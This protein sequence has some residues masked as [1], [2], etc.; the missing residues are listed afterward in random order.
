MNNYYKTFRTKGTDRDELNKQTLY[1]LYKR[2]KKESTQP[3]YDTHIAEDNT[4]QADLLYMPVD[5][6]YRYALVIVDIGTGRVEAE[7]L[8]SRTADVVRDAFKTIYTDKKR[9][10]RFPKLLQVDD[11]GEFKG[12]CEA[13]LESKGVLLR[14]GKAG[15]SRQ[16]A[17]VEKLNGDIA[18]SLFMRMTAEELLNN[19]KS[20]EWIQ[21]LPVVIKALNEEREHEADVN[22]KYGDPIVS[23]GDEDLLEAGTKVRIMLDKPREL[24][25]VKLSGKFRMGDIR[26]NPK[27][28]SVETFLFVPEQPVMYRLNELK[29]VQFT[30]EQ[31]QVV[32]EE[33]MPPVS[34]LRKWKVERIVDKAKRNGRVVYL[35]KWAGFSESDNTW[36]P[37]AKLLID[38]PSLVKDYEHE[39]K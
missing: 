28:Y 18:R 17:V 34:V 20:V 13:W 38:V 11:G 22:H 21:D 26:W 29:Y 9:G 37:R 39:A 6:G 31:L 36:E 1:K 33:D 8:K 24:L 15:R 16:Q 10:L 19:E 35:V 30:R 27:I 2:P 7:P 14:H 4:H 12:E 23:K 3:H 32:G 25:G 5:D